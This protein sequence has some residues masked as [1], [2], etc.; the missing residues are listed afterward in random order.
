MARKGAAVV[1]DVVNRDD[2][3]VFQA[4]DRASRES[5][6]SSSLWTESTLMATVRC[7]GIVRQYRTPCRLPQGGRRSDSGSL[8][9]N[10]GF[11]IAAVRVRRGAGRSIARTVLTH[12]QSDMLQRPSTA[13]LYLPDWKGWRALFHPEPVRPK[14]D[15]PPGSSRQA[16]GDDLLDAEASEEPGGKPG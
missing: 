2:V 11:A 10:L 3:V 1:T 12:P 4:A 6:R 13:T 16:W 8:C 14:R 7:S 15:A 5:A 9:W